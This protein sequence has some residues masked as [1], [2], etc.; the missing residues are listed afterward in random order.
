VRALPALLLLALLALAAPASAATGP[1]IPGG[2]GP[3]C[4]IWKG[5]VTFI[6]D[7]DTINVD[8]AHDGTSKP[9]SIRFTGINAMELRRYSK[10]RARRRGDCHGVAATNRLEHFLRAAHMR[11]RLAAQ[12]PRSRSGHRLR[13]NVSVRLHGA[14]VDLDRVIISEGYALWL[15]NGVEWAWNAEYHQLVLQA[16]A[17]HLRLW[18]PTGCGVGPSPNA[19]LTM[20]LNY[21]A[22]H[23]DGQNVNGEWARIT[24]PSG[25]P[26]PIAHWWF[27]DSALRRYTFPPGAVIP[28]HDSIL[29]RAGKGPSG[30]HEF[31]WG[32]STPP[33]ENPT[34][35][36]RAIGDGAYLFDTL[37]NIRAFV[38]YP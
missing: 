7:G 15:P 13:R 11:V 5:K 32:L 27:R 24:N 30:G 8:I 18:N 33:F 34:Y 17:A 10:Y 6:A 12:D 4:H 19:G 22:D 23:N 29:V 2:G 35:D 38:I 14:W 36:R 31:H 9:K 20:Q 25:A 16:A 21:D 1:C 28:A 37:G 3:T 26:V